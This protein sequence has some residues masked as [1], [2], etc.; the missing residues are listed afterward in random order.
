MLH[1]VVFASGPNRPS[2]ITAAYYSAPS[3]AGVFAAGTTYWVCGLDST[4]PNSATPQATSVALQQ[5]TLNLLTA[6]AIPKA[7]RLHPSVATPYMTAAQ[8]AKQL[9]VGG[10]SGSEG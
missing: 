7:G 9:P 5:I 3:G 2:L 8:L 10:A 4:C 1:G 6:F